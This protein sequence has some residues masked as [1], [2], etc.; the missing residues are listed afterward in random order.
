VGKE[1]VPLEGLHADELSAAL[2]EYIERH[3]SPD[4]QGHS[5]AEEDY[6]EFSDNASTSESYQIHIV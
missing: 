2:D 3:Q 4:N 5:V 1:V 6:D